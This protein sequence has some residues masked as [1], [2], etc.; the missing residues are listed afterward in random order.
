MMD[1]VWCVNVLWGVCM[2]GMQGWECCCLSRRER[3]TRFSTCKTYTSNSYMTMYSFLYYL[4]K[5]KV[6]SEEAHV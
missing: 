6:R 3:M 1:N 4:F 5:K 2:M